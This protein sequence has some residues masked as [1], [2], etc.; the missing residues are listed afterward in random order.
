MMD[1]INSDYLVLL[2]I[3]IRTVSSRS[4]RIETAGFY[5]SN[6]HIFNILDFASTTRPAA[7]VHELLR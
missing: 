2:F 6:C 3:A 4:Q 7:K 5:N 1:I